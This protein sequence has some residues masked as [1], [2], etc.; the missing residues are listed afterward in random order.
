MASRHAALLDDD[1]LTVRRNGGGAG[2]SSAAR[3]A[4]AAD[5]DILIDVDAT[6]SV[7]VELPAGEAPAS[8]PVFF[9]G[10]PVADADNAIKM[11]LHEHPATAPYTCVSLSLEFADGACAGGRRRTG[12][13]RR[14]G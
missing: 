14:S 6:F 10:I 9:D 2:P 5:D 1:E 12:C 7:A 8:P 4:A 13:R 3:V 11:A